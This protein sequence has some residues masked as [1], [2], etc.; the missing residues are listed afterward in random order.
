MHILPLKLFVPSL[1]LAVFSTKNGRLSNECFLTL[2]INEIFN[3]EN[4][5]QE[6]YR[7]FFQ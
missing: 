1:F 7:D 4:K 6:K 5:K 3:K 2:L